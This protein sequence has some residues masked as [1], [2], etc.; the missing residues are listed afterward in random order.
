[1]FLENGLAVQRRE[2]WKTIPTPARAM[3]YDGQP[4]VSTPSSLTEPASGRSMPMTSFITVDLARAVRS[5]QAENLAVVQVEADVVDGHQAAVAFDEAARF[6]RVPRV[7]SRTQVHGRAGHPERTGSRPARCCYHEGVEL[8]E[9]PQELGPDHQKNCADGGPK[10]VRRP[11]STAPMMICTPIPISIIV[12]TD[13][14]P[15]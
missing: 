8:A 5:D 7:L 14:A 9:R 3:R 13:A 15:M 1:M 10:M 6:E 4:T 2:C 11:P 12:P